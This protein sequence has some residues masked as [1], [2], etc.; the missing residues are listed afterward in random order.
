MILD[1]PTVN[2]EMGHLGFALYP[3]YAVPQAFSIVPH[4]V[5]QMEAGDLL[6]MRG[7]HVLH[8]GVTLADEGE[9]I[10]VVYAYDEVG[11]RPNPIR[12]KIARVLNY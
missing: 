3:L 1:N 9:R 10:L 7:S 12:D 5:T 6:I 11:K 4:Q 2:Y 8:R